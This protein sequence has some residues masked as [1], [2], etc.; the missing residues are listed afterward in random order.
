MIRDTYTD[1]TPKGAFQSLTCASEKR[2]W[3][4]VRV[5]AAKTQLLILFQWVRNIT[6]EIHVTGQMVRS[7]ARL[8]LVG[9]LGRLLHL[10]LHCQV[11]RELTL[12]RLRQLKQAEAREASA[13]DR[14]VADGG[15]GRGA[16]L[17]TARSTPLQKFGYFSILFLKT[18]KVF[19]NIFKIKCP[20]SV[21]KLSFGGR[22]VLAP[23]NPTPLIKIS[24]RRPWLRTI[25]QSAR[26]QRQNN[27]NSPG[28]W[29]CFE[30]E[31]RGAA[32]IITGSPLSSRAMLLWQ[33]R[34]WSWRPHRET[35][36]M[37]LQVKTPGLRAEDP[38][39]CSG[40]RNL[41]SK[42]VQ[43]HYG[44]AVHWPWDLGHSQRQGPH[45]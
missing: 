12:P 1:S 3:R 10:G 8:K 18:Y 28:T 40:G 4:E 17:K 13:A 9:F 39:G 26:L 22:W 29:S 25:I 7:G 5:A 16:L 30:R 23:M 6:C 14:G 37:R 45:Q 35:L 24:W 31:M 38:A 19:V 43:E 2:I 33:R 41:S 21:E 27:N 32:R 11:M 42:K 34:G 15:G 36:S 20:K 44:V